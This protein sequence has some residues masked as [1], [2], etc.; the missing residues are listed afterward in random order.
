LLRK[1]G[2]SPR[3]ARDQEKWLEIG[4]VVARGAHF[5][6][7]TTAAGFDRGQHFKILMVGYR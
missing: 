5:S 2:N 7:A 3:R 4:V 1:T 6:V